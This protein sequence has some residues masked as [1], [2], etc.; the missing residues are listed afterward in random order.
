LPGHGPAYRSLLHALTCR[1][2]GI[3]HLRTR[4]YRPRT[5]GKAECFIQTL[6]VG[7]AYGAIYGSSEERTRALPGW[8]AFYNHRRPHGSLGHQTPLARLHAVMNNVLGSH[9]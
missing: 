2:P 6:L 1:A 9:N 7:W 4:P 3:K 5:N 8:I